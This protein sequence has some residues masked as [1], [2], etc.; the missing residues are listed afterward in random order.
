MT[1]SITKR[2]FSALA[3]TAAA[4]TIG[5]PVAEA[6]S[7]DAFERAVQG[8]QT[9]QNHTFVGSPDVIDRAIAAR[10]S[11]QVQTAL[12][13]RERALTERP[14]STTTPGPDAFERAL[15]THADEQTLKTAAMLD[16]RERGLGEQRTLASQAS[17]T[18][19]EGFD[20]DE[21]GMGAAAGLVL[22]GGLGA[23]A[24]RRSGRVTTA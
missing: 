21:F 1:L 2:R 5:A 10:E 6:Q 4:L 14:T 24:L 3:L 22:L 13:T 17:V 11:N 19:S 12:D 18:G 16:A 9:Q 15:I 20:W 7:P 23:L 8:R